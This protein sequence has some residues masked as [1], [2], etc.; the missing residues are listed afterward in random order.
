MSTTDRPHAGAFDSAPELCVSPALATLWQE[1]RRCTLCAKRLPLGPRPI[2]RPSSRARLLIVGQAP[3]IRVH[4]SGLPWNDPSG[5]RLR[6]WLGLDRAAFYDPERVAI[7]PMG[8]CY[9]GRGARGDR[10]PR[11]ECAPRWHPPLLAAMPQLELIL[12]VGRYAQRGF[13]G[14]AVKPTSS[15]T[16]AAWAEYGPRFFPLPHPSPRNHAWLRDRPWFAAEVLPA[17]RR[18]L[19]ALCSPSAM[20]ED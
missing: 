5:D 17:L 16:V 1:V 3:G 2:L 11:P 9:P 18:R 12:L 8:F 14:A 13:L 20:T 6:V 19:A 4:Q 15:A 7:M 10:P